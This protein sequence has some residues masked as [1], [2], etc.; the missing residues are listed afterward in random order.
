MREVNVMREV[1]GLLRQRVGGLQGELRLVREEVPVVVSETVGACAGRG[2][3][4]DGRLDEAASG[5]A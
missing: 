1:V 4:S 2:A 3:A 5:T